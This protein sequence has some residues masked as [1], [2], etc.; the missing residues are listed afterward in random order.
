[1]ATGKLTYLETPEHEVETVCRLAA[2]PL[3]GV[4][5]NVGGESELQLRDL[6]HR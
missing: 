1:M 4:A 2:G 6:Q 5:A 3:A